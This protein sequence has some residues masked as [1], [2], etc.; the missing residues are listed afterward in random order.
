MNEPT[1]PH[2]PPASSFVRKWLSLFFEF[3]F[4]FTF[5]FEFE[6]EFEFKFEFFSSVTAATA[7]VAVDV[8][9]VGADVGFDFAIDDDDDDDDDVVADVVADSL[10]FIALLI[11]FLTVGYIPIL[12]PAYNNPLRKVGR[13]PGV[14][15]SKNPSFLTI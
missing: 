6:F 2:R 10:S 13:R 8:D 11:K 9:T 4:T 15:S 7:A 1:A 12:L 3:T 14:Q 5:T